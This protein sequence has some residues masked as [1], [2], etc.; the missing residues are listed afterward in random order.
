ERSR[1]R[2]ASLGRRRSMLRPSNRDEFTPGTK[3]KLERRAGMRCSNPECRRQTLAPTSTGDEFIQ[4]GV[5][6]HIEAA[7]PLGP[8]FRENMTRVERRSEAN[9]IWLCQDCSKVVDSKD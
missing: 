4:K 1:Y 8:R 9:G 6:S 5:A 3:R 2:R 7:S